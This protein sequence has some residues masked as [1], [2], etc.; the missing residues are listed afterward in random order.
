MTAYHHG[1]TG[2]ERFEN[3]NGA[4]KALKRMRKRHSGRFNIYRCPFCHGWHLT[5]Y[6]KVSRGQIER[7][8]EKLLDRGP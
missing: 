6:G 7:K 5:H 8:I 1:C 4:S 2:K 3:A